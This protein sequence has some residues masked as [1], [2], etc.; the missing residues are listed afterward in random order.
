LGSFQHAGSAVAEA[1]L[2]LTRTVTAYEYR[3]APGDVARLLGA[4]PESEALR[5]QTVRV[6]GGRPLDVV[7]EW[8]PLRF[9]TPISRADA[10]APGVWETLRRHGHT[11]DVVRQTITAAAASAADAALL[12]VATGTPVLLIRR[13]A[14]LAGDTPL[15]L[16]EHRYLGHRFRLEVQFRGWPATAGHESPGVTTIPL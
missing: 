1:G 16:S 7:V 8:V 3:P 4:A 13:L 2:P 15:A 9:A 5:V 10:E 11:I 12:D 14:V 6:T